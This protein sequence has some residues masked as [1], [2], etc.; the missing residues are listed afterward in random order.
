MPDD[1][2]EY[3]PLMTM[4]APGASGTFSPRVDAG[5]GRGYV[6][7]DPE[8]TVKHDRNEIPTPEPVKTRRQSQGMAGSVSAVPPPSHK[9]A[10]A[11]AIQEQS[12]QS[13][14]D[15]AALAEKMRREWELQHQAVLAAG[16]SVRQQEGQGA[17]PDWLTNYMDG[18]K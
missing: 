16:P 15:L 6:D 1:D 8:V 10:V 9:V 4:E 17:A 12:H 14:Q 11:Q 5:T 13:N 18:S 3:I 2:L 7:Y